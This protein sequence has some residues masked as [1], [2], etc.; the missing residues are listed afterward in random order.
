MLIPAV[1]FCQ[2]PKGVYP[3][4]SGTDAF[5]FYYRNVTGHEGNV[6]GHKMTKDSDLDANLGILRFVH[7]SGLGSSGWTFAPNV[8]I[9]FGSMH[10]EQTSKSLNQTSSGFADPQLVLALYSPT[11]KGANGIQLFLGEYIT[12]PLGDYHNDQA[13]NM[14]AN[15]WAFKQEAGLGWKPFKKLTLETIFDWEVYTKNDDYMKGNNL[16]KN[17]WF[18]VLEHISWDFNDKLFMTITPQYQWGAAQQL[19]GKDVANSKVG[20]FSGWFTAGVK[21]NDYSQLMMQLIHDFDAK[22]GLAQ[23]QIRFRYAFFF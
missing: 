3:A 4:P 9:P 16:D 5:L 8:I 7:W 14:G 15:R 23:D 10:L 18:S 21:L 12:V 19:N 11:P 2:D 20:T 6:D 1:G 13:V 17:A 22:N